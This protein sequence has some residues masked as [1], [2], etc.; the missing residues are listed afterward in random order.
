MAKLEGAKLLVVPLAAGIVLGAAAFALRSGERPAGTAAAAS[1]AAV[2]LCDA[3]E[4]G[5]RLEFGGRVLDYEGRPLARASVVAYH[6]DREGLYN[7]RR[8]PT[9]VPR[10]RG[11]AVT[12]DDGGFRFLTVR[13]GPYPE[14]TEPAH[15]HLTVT[16]PAHHVRH[17]AL[18]F[19]DDP[20][21]TPA[22]R[23]AA[24]DAPQGETVVVT[25]ERSPG[26]GWSFTHDVR[27]EGN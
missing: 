26:G 5:E 8:S 10:I 13:P 24:R 14:G 22:R 1:A 12:G 7:P 18:W 6:A 25:P 2:A 16:A 27:L 11:V 9:R 15:I 19:S 21:A 23:A 4:P 20:L 3:E 17:T